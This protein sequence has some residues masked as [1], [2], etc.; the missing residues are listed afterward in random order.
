M[1][2]RV[3]LPPEPGLAA[4]AGRNAGVAQRL[5]HVEDLVFVVPGERDLARA[6]Q[7][8]VVFL[9]VV[10][11]VG[12]G[13]EKTGARHDLGA[14]ERRG[15]ERNE[16]GLDRPAEP[17]LD[18]GEL[19][20]RADPFEEVEARSRDLRAAF[21]VDRVEK[22]AE[23][24]VV[25]RFEVE[26][27]LRPD[28][29]ERD[30]VVFTAGGNAVDDDVLD[31]ADLV[32]EHRLRFRDRLLPGLHLGGELLG[33]R[34][35]CGLLVFRCGGDGLAERVLLCSCGLERL[36][37]GP[38]SQVCGNR[39]IDGR[40]GNP[41]RLLRTAHGVGILAQQLRIDHVPI[42]LTP[43]QAPTRERAHT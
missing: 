18:E 14:H 30:E 26:R 32:G 40:D 2:P 5:R 35:E 29:F 31:A 10:D 19:E 34:D 8:E 9:E 20:P 4:V 22:F 21:H 28:L 37:R 15:D 7:V 27:R 12:V 36:D 38:A 43:P 25:A 16:A 42:L 13:S 24:E 33:L 41:S 3:S 1:M 17:H 6:G 11:L 39:L 23:F